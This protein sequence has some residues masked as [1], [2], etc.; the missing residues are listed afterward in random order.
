LNAADLHAQLMS[1]GVDVRAEDGR[2]RVNA[3]RGILTEQMQQAVV[4]HKGELL[5]LLAERAAAASNTVRRVSRDGPLPLSLFQERLWVLHRL[6]P[7][8]TAY[9]MATVWPMAAEAAALRRA[10]A[11]VVRRHEILRATFRDEGV[12]PQLHL[13]PPEAVRVDL[14]GLDQMG[15]SEQKVALA[16][17]LGLA[18]ATP[19]DLALDPPVRFTVYQLAPGRS[20]ILVSAHHIA[21]DAWSMALLHREIADAHAAVVAGLP[22]GPLPL[23]YVD[24]ADWQ[25]RGQSAGAL[26]SELAWWEGRLAGL[27]QLCAFP[28]DQVSAGRAT[29]AVRGRRLSAEV[30]EGIRRLAR[31]AGATVYMVLLA[32]CATV[33]RAHARLDDIVLGSPTG[34]RERAEFESMLGPFVNLLVLR[35]DLADDPSFRELTV[36]A[37][38]AVLDAHAHRQ[39]PFE[40]LVER[41]KP[42][43]ILNR[44]P[45]FQVAVVLH[46]A[47]PEQGQGISGGGAIHDLT[48]FVREVDGCF[49]SALEFRS[50]L[51]AP[52]TIDRIGAHLETVLTTAA[53][54]PGR[55]IRAIPL[56]SPR[57]REQVIADFNATSV[58]VP[59][60]TFAAQ[61]ARQA[62]L[63]PAACA[64]RFEGDELSYVALD[65]RATV[66]ARRLRALGVA[67]GV[68]VGLCLERSLDLVAALVAVHQ[69]GGAYVPL[70]PALPLERLRFM[71]ADSGARVLLTSGEAADGL[72][73]E[74]VAILDLA[75]DAGEDFDAAPLDLTAGPTDPAYVIYTSGSTGRPKG[76]AVAQGALSNFLAAMRA[77]PGLRADDVLMAVTTISF[78]IAALELCLPLIV[79]AR[80]ELVARETA[81]DGEALAGALA[82]SG[83]TILQ[84]TPTAWRQL[85]DAGWR[86][87]AGFRAL[88]GGE[89]LPR[90]LADALIERV[91]ELWNLYGPTETTI[92]STAGRVERG[93]D[94]V[95][96]GRPIANT[97]VYVLDA[98]GSPV[99]VG[100]PGEIFIAGDGL[101]IGYH[102]RPALTAERF[103]PESFAVAPG[104]RMYRTGD[105]GRW[106]SDGQLYHLG[107]LDHQVKIRGLRIELG[108]IEAAIAAHEAVRQAVVVAHEATP[109]NVRL[110]AYVVWHDGEDLT[111]SD[112]RRY[113]RRELPDYMIPS[114]VI[115]LDRIPQTPNG[116]VD[117]KALPD[118]F[119]NA[120]RSAA[121]HEPPAPGREQQMAAI[122]RDVL[123]LERI[124][125]EDNFFELGGHSLL[126]LRVATAVE[127]QMGIRM[128]PRALFFQSLRQVV[129]GLGHLT[130]AAANGAGR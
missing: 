35:L 74:G 106:G 112:M 24:Y 11:E 89:A 130:A 73:T 18:T 30:S 80:I 88:C 60:E 7:D 101:A 37:R 16:A 54:D 122:W 85:V 129:T 19:F 31:E 91:T 29:G 47:G 75:A 6:D 12:G 8:S 4:A 126:S 23:Q 83:A 90:D 115:A 69:A 118:P 45:L 34:V 42:V 13:L 111:V 99:P 78:D 3:A 117:R 26:A 36:R 48:W 98:A 125:A 95:S 56:L 28:V 116:K 33:L 104:V 105:L 63:T 94:P 127:K 39:V 77:E 1:L 38:D 15:E 52:E 86:G 76:V 123:R 2:L 20:A 5:A 124:G 81:A 128:D 96:I 44:S 66:L 93:T 61:F 57:E 58:E 64:L 87:P 53:R 50:D 32:A 107:R 55:R 121:R 25:R 102:G 59:R 79:G 67:P 97:R 103:V 109:G 46:N 41:L 72:E 113:L 100:I 14:V 22:G 110:I 84:A 92:W 65:R 62:A 119:Q 40:M 21:L 71:L 82:T 120:P 49:E 108:E 43:R 17:D 10:V 70:D 68:L 51:Y 114:L 27:P 9:N